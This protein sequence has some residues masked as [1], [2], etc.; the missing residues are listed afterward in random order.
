M[1]ILSTAV[2][3]PLI[4]DREIAVAVPPS[5]TLNVTVLVL[6]DVI[7]VIPVRS[8][9][10]LILT[11]TSPLMFIFA[12]SE[13]VI[14]SKSRIY[15]SDEPLGTTILMTE[16]PSPSIVVKPAICAGVSVTSELT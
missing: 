13:I 11:V 7:A 9:A 8:E 10:S 15:V 4:S 14:A 16:L 2:N 6:L 3:V 5:I 12:R 1:I